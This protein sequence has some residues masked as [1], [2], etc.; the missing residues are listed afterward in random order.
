MKHL[1]GFSIFE[2]YNEIKE[3]ELFINN[4]LA[5]VLD[6]YEVDVKDKVEEYGHDGRYKEYFI[7]ISIKKSEFKWDQ[8]KDDFIPFL[9]LLNNN[10]KIK[11][12]VFYEKKFFIG[13]AY[14]FSNVED[15]L[16]DDVSIKNSLREI[17]VVI[18]KN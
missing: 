18:D 7:N 14:S 8:I 10:Y 12:I 3:I 9:E 1:R 17:I 5:Y 4:N 16:N 15:I 11:H 13:W 2:N 6:D